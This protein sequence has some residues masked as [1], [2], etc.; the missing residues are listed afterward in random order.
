MRLELTGNDQSSVLV[1]R[2]LLQGS[3]GSRLTQRRPRSTKKTTLARS[4]DHG[5]RR[6]R[7]RAEVEQ[8]EPPWASSPWEEVR[9]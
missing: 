2:A 1:I 9:A 8:G 7:F 3:F 5:A 4:A 6:G